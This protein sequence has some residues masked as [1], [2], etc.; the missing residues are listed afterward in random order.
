M[1]MKTLQISALKYYNAIKIN[2]EDGWNLDGRT[3]TIQKFNQI[4]N[5]FVVVYQV[6]IFG[7]ERPVNQLYFS[8]HNYK[9]M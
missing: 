4:F 3:A 5:R 1:P 2:Q 7:I 9:F 8:V 6:I